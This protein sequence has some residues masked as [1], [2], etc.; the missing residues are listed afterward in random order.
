MPEIEQPWSKPIEEVLR[1]LEV[2]GAAGLDV[3]EVAARMTRYGRNR[4]RAIRKKSAWRI[5]LDQFKSL[6]IALLGVAALLSY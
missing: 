1:I 4:L 6:I 5:L 3:D 2:D